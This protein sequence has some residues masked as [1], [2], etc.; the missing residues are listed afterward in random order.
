MRDRTKSTEINVDAALAERL[1]DVRVQQGLHSIE[2]AME[3][4]LRRGIRR[5]GEQLIGRRRTLN[6]VK[7]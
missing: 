1:E 3:F 6:I 4:L 7:G 2:H 5:S